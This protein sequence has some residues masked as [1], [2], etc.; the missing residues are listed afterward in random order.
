MFPQLPEKS[1]LTGKDVKKIFSTA[2]LIELMAK[3]YKMGISPSKVLNPHP[4]SYTIPS[5]H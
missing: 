1:M 4:I 5:T 3:K 2:F